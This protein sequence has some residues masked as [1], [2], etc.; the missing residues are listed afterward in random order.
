MGVMLPQ[1]IIGPWNLILCGNPVQTCL[2]QFFFLRTFFKFFFPEHF[3][4][5]S[6]G[7]GLETLSLGLGLEN[8]GLGL[9]LGLCCLDSNT[10]L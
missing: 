6:L 2:F 9:C 8:L 4:S 7:L 1:S 10:S 5:L 3:Q